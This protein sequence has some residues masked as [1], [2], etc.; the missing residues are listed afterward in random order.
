[1]NLFEDTCI[2]SKSNISLEDLKI[3]IIQLYLHLRSLIKVKIY[4][5]YFHSLSNLVL[6]QRLKQSQRR[7]TASS[8]RRQPSW[9]TMWMNFW[10]G[11][12]AKFGSRSNRMRNPTA[13][14][15]KFR[16]VWTKAN[17]SFTKSSARKKERRNRVKTSTFY[18]F[19]CNFCSVTY[20]IG[21]QCA[22]DSYIFKI[23]ILFNVVIVV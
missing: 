6:F 16:G 13:D 19:M 10:W 4:T 14:W 3:G 11:F 17:K 22:V 1:M 8:S 21:S 5:A 12:W 23:K 20:G 15:S 2:I 7:T 18:R 9:T